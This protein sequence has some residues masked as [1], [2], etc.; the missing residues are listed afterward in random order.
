MLSYNGEVF[1]YLRKHQAVGITNSQPVDF[2]LLLAPYFAERYFNPIHIFHLNESIGYIGLIPLVFTVTGIW[3]ARNRYKKSFLLALVILTIIMLGK[4]AYFTTIIDGVLP[5]FEMIRHTNLFIF[6]FI[7]CMS[8]F[9]CIGFKTV[10][11]IRDEAQL[12]SQL[13]KLR[14]IGFAIILGGI[15]ITLLFSLFHHITWKGLID[16]AFPALMEYDF[17]EFTKSRSYTLLNVAL[18]LLGGTLLYRCIKRQTLSRRIIFILFVFLIF[19]DLEMFDRFLFNYVTDPKNIELKHSTDIRTLSAKRIYEHRTKFP[20]TG[21]P[22]LISKV[23]SATLTMNLWGTHF[24]ELKDYYQ[25]RTSEISE[26][27][28]EFYYFH[29]YATRL[30]HD[31]SKL[32]HLARLMNNNS[33]HTNADK[34]LIILSYDHH[35]QYIIETLNTIL[36]DADARNI[37]FYHYRTEILKHISHE[38]DMSKYFPAHVSLPGEVVSGRSQNGNTIQNKL[39]V[40]LLEKMFHLQSGYD[41]LFEAVRNTNGDHPISLCVLFPELLQADKEDELIVLLNRIIN[42]TEK[43]RKFI[44]AFYS[45][46]WKMHFGQYYSLEGSTRYED[47]KFGRTM[48][49]YFFPVKATP[50]DL[51]LSFSGVSKPILRLVDLSDVVSRSSYEDNM[52]EWHA[53]LSDEKVILE[54]KIPEKFRLTQETISSPTPSNNNIGTVTIEYYNPNQLSVRVSAKKPSLLYFS[55]V[56]TDDWKVSVDGK[57]DKIY[58]ANFEFKAVLI[59]SGSHQIVFEYDPILYKLALLAYSLAI[60]VSLG[61]WLASWLREKKTEGRGAPSPTDS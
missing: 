17:K 35:R 6:P 31:L 42:D 2:L 4:N 54:D 22:P 16:S 25:L 18:F 55:D 7:F 51:L 37:F 12:S 39:L 61:G 1:P 44:K 57:R 9:T 34:N 20:F 58:K 60:I 19:L 30:P 48:M 52:M 11:Q 41:N 13:K 50:T 27:L 26:Q 59:D 56:Y 49:E 38:T 10:W 46:F 33:H 8:Y 45:D 24:F 21:Y 43:R 47:Q 28:N 3:I 14:R 40:K 36:D 32:L 15:S 5:V 23:H 29:E 53:H